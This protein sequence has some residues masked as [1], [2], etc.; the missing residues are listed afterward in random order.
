MET[1]KNQL[2]TVSEISISYSPKVNPSRKP[3]ITTADQAY[4]LFIKHWNMDKIYCCEQCLMML[5]NRRGY[6][7][8]IVELS[9]G[10][11][12]GTV[13][14]LK[15]IFATALK[16]LASSFI[17]CHNHPS[18]DVKPS[19]EDI[20]ITRRIREAGEILGIELADHLIISPSGFLSMSG[21]GYI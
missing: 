21:E 11:L 12:S 5:L 3:K 16:A 18:G 4:M 7:L 13:I 8:G 15:I 14:D 1:S 10:G 6:V 9:S 19:D 2:S 17:L 20:R